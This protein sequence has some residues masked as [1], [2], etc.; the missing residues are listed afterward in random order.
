MMTLKQTALKQTLTTT[1]ALAAGMAFGARAQAAQPALVTPAWLQTH[2]HAP[3]LVVLEIYDSTAQAPDFAAGHVPGAVFTGFINDGWRATVNN[4]PA[5]LPP[6]AD[7]A[8]VIGG[9]GIGP[10]SQVVL[11][12]RGTA[13][14]DFTA[15][16]RVFWSLRMSG[17]AD[18]AILNGGEVA[19]AA[20]GAP[21]ATGAPVAPRP[22]AFTPHLSPGL[23]VTLADVAADL[24]S[25]QAVLVDARPP[26]QFE[27]RAVSPVVKAP[28]TLPGALNL[29]AAALETIDGEGLLPPARLQAALAKAGVPAAKPAI[30]FCN[31]GILG[32]L[33]WFVLREVLGNPHVA[34]YDGSMAEWTADPARP[35]V[36]GKS[37]F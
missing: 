15:T 24:T 29:P 17:V 19:W 9:F 21:V 36:A 31:T 26:A 6:P 2:L 10:H 30:T 13:R 28:G 12:T 32:S 23:D 22:V 4:V 11:V 5:M 37:A 16:T 34:L 33:D 3:G 25:H 14:G 35:V 1:L 27:G 20:S 18:V 8:K 7:I